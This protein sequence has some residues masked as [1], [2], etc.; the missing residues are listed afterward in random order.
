MRNYI[1]RLHLHIHFRDDILKCFRI[2]VKNV[3]IS[4]KHVY[5]RPTL[6]SRCD[7]ISDVIVMKFIV[8]DDLHII[9]LYMMLN[10]VSSE[11]FEIFKSDEKFSSM[12]T[13]S[14]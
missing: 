12:R 14:S 6:L 11:N 8:V 2:I 7:I 9:F 10:H 1:A 5:R 3:A 13:F 4:F